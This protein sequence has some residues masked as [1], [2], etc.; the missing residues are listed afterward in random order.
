KELRLQLGKAAASAL[1]DVRYQVPDAEYS[2]D[3]A[4]MIAIAGFFRWKK[5]DDFQ[6]KK[7]FENWRVMKT[8]AS[9][10]LGKKS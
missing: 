6:K 7:S 1:P 3:N 10:N 5:M 8:E 4:A 9:M 2:I